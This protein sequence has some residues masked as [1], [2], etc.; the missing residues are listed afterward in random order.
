MSGLQRCLLVVTTFAL[1]RAA[2]ARFGSDNP[3]AMF[4]FAGVRLKAR[5]SNALLQGQFRHSEVRAQADD[6]AHTLAEAW[7]GAAT[8]WNDSRVTY[9]IHFMTPAMRHVPGQRSL[10]GA[11]INFE[12]NL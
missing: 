9:A 7:V 3:A 4:L 5:A 10:I 2:L 12:R 8:R 11:G 1:A 6:L